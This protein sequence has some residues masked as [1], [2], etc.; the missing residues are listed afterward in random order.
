MG[1]FAKGSSTATKERGGS[2]VKVSQSQELLLLTM[3]P[4]SHL[5]GRVNVNAP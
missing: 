5:C 1:H 2:E 4:H 3:R